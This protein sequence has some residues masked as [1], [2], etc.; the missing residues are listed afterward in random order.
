MSKGL[1]GFILRDALI[2][3][4][5]G[6]PTAAQM[7]SKGLWIPMMTDMLMIAS[8]AKQVIIV[9]SAHN[10][11]AFFHSAPRICLNAT[12]SYFPSQVPG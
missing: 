5:N 3:I 7:G 4:G 6:T 2:G 9:K 8:D 12:V 11:H 10:L 1:R